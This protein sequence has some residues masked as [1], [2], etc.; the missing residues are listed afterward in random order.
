MLL[1]QFSL[2]SYNRIKS[3]SRGVTSNDCLM[4]FSTIANSLTFAEC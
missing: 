3:C 2:S 4:V 1:L